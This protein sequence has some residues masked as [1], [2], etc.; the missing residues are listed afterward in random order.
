MTYPII[1]EFTD[2]AFGVVHDQDGDDHHVQIS[3]HCYSLR[4]LKRMIFVIMRKHNQTVQCIL[5][6]RDNNELSDL[7]ND[8]TEESTI[9]I[10]GN[11]TMSPKP[12]ES[13][14]VH[15]YEIKIT[16]VDVICRA[17]ELPFFVADANEILVVDEDED[18]NK[19]GKDE[20]D[21][22]T[23]EDNRIKVPRQARLANRWLDIRAFNNYDIIRLRSFLLNA[24]RGVA[25]GDGFIEV[26]TPKII[27]AVSESGSSVFELQYFNR[28]AYLAQ[29]PQLYKQMLINSGLRGIF[30]VGPVFR[31]ENAN[32]YRHLCE[33]TGMD[34]EFPIEP[35]ENHYDV[36][37]KI[38]NILFRGFTNL[39]AKNS[40]L[41][42]SI[43]A[44]TG[45]DGYIMPE[46]PVI[47]D[48]CDGCDMLCSAGF[49]QDKNEDVGSVN[50]KELGKLVKAK[51]NA[52]IFVLI[53]YPSSARPFYTMVDY[54]TDADGSRVYSK[55]SRSF[56]IIMRN[57]EISSGAQRNHDPEILKE[58]IAM[59]GIELDFENKTTGLE[60]YVRSFE[61]GSMP[62]GGSGI[63]VERIAMLYLGLPNVRSVSLFPRDSRT[64]TP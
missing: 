17:A 19:T 48:F 53:N 43:W 13:C 59:H 22:N 4:K 51:Y 40:D 57:N 9:T 45:V 61:F 50:E 31:A 29:S 26:S 64:I 14:D 56:D 42:D 6:K 37:R 11:I 62:H 18:D 54:E 46:Q 52:D 8:L 20:A 24:M 23:N 41:I 27:P 55:Y 21:V 39:Y 60:D 28:K 12:V 32:T 15:K 36:V 2:K 63:G 49:E 30:E 3:G 7:L 58:R 34:F 35:S 25:L 10:R 33:F 16:D 44:M 1:R 38:W 47:I 5:M